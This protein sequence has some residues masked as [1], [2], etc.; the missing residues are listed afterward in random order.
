METLTLTP[1]PLVLPPLASPV[2]QGDYRGYPLASRI[3]RKGKTLWRSTKLVTSQGHP[4]EYESLQY[5]RDVIDRH[6]KAEADAKAYAEARPIIEGKIRQLL[7]DQAIWDYESMM[8]ALGWEGIEG[9]KLFNRVLGEFSGHLYTGSTICWRTKEISDLRKAARDDVGT[10]ASCPVYIVP[11]SKTKPR[12][13]G[14]MY[15]GNRWGTDWNSSLLVTVGEN[16][17]AKKQ[18]QG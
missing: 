18:K 11:N 5:L 17:K 16:W 9:E 6:I 1:T 4:M 3:T 8:T 13:T 14:K 2:P 7:K 12:L 15:K 10:Y